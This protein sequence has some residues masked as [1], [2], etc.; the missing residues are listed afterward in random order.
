MRKLSS[1]ALTCL[2]IGCGTNS[3][4][5]ETVTSETPSSIGTP[6]SSAPKSSS[7]SGIA[8]KP[9]AKVTENDAAVDQLVQRAQS[10]VVARQGRVA[11]EALSQAIGLAPGRSHLFHTRADV[12]NL[13]G[14]YA[15]ARADFSLAIQLDPTNAN[16]YNARGYFLMTRGAPNE[17]LADFTRAVELNPKFTVALNNRGLI[18]LAQND[19]AAAIADFSQAVSLDGKYVD[20]LNNR[21]FAQMKQGKLNEALVDLKRTVELKPDYTTAWNNCGLVYME[22]ENYPGAVIAFSEA[23]KL[24]PFDARWLNH[25]RAALQRLEKFE[26]ANV[27]AQ[28]IRWI[29][30]LTQL[31]QKSSQRPNDSKLW[32]ARAE[33]L[34]N[35]EQFAPAIQ[36]Y[37]RV[38]LLQ[39]NSKAA[40]LGR[41]AAWLKTGDAP[42]AI[43]DC[44]SVI[45]DDPS[46]M[47]HSI[48][49]EAWLAME[50]VN[51]AISDLEQA[52][53]MDDV[54]VAAYQKRAAEHK[55]AGKKA[56]ADED[57]AKAQYLQDALAGKLTP[58]TALEQVPFPTN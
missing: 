35:G 9:T 25:R 46:P 45:K 7:S 24:A 10:A 37:T 50:D 21:G 38:L 41:A 30:E 47:A 52:Q 36:D 54:L 23:I 33:H 20:A 1:L 57:L 3:T 16:L 19:Y 4:P 2:L 51:K 32:L 55:A 13:M 31:T 29:E 12:Y 14:E 58:R 39:P 40:L 49:G 26:E 53:R 48:R 8:A 15:N 44:D 43:A 27:D 56:E 18:R 6:E 42:K 5:T 17:S 28:K 34:T 11:V 22:Q